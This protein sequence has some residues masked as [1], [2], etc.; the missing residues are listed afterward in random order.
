[1]ENISKKTALI[2]GASEG[3][4]FALAKIFVEKGYDLILVARDLKKLNIAKRELE[5]YNSNVKLISKDLSIK[6]SAKEIFN[7]IKRHEIKI[8]ILVNNAGFGKYGLFNEID[9]NENLRMINL[10]MISLTELTY[11][12]LNEMIKNKKGKILNVASTAAFQPGPLMSSYYATKAYVLNLSEGIQKE[13]QEKRERGID[14]SVSTLC[15]GPTITGFQK[16]ANLNNSKLFKNAMSSDDVAIAGYNGLIKNK[17]V[18]IP[19]FKNK[20]LY[21]ISKI[22][23]RNARNTI[24]LNMN[25]ANVR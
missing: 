20:L 21:F 6:D 15:P 18:I 23:P 13:L 11:L 1:M 10:N 2:T 25:R 24:I 19:G 16:K 5:K 8:D 22:S 3:I 9:L 14:V 12:F 4:G 7:I 17:T